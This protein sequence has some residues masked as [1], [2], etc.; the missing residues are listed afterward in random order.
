LRGIGVGLLLSG[1]SCG[2]LSTPVVLHLL[3]QLLLCLAGTTICRA[4][5]SSLVA[6]AVVTA[7]PASATTSSTTTTRRA[8]AR[9]RDIAVDSIGNGFG[10]VTATA[11]AAG[12]VRAF[13]TTGAQATR[14]A[15]GA[16]YAVE[17]CVAIGGSFTATRDKGETDGLALRVGAV[18]FA[19]RLMSIGQAFICDVCN[20]LGASG[21]V[22]DEGKGGNGAD[23]SEEVLEHPLVLCSWGI[24]RRGG[25]THFE[26]AFGNVVVKVLHADLGQGATTA[27]RL[28]T[29]RL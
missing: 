22:I 2:G 1:L 5:A 17:E 24:A 28:A 26:I 10:D 25:D 21:A 9:S 11:T 6:S 19:N 7:I 12:T 20:A 16:L 4:T 14:V 15:L 18:E 23:A 13:F 29:L 8:L 27:L 3:V